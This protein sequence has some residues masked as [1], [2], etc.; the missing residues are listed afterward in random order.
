M[1]TLTIKLPQRLA[2]QLEA[3]ARRLNLPKSRMARQ[4]L[5]EGL[6]SKQTKGGRKKSFHDL[7]KEHCGSFR[8]PPDLSTNPK[9]MDGFA[10][11]GKR[12]HRRRAARGLFKR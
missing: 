4:F 7:A 11:E 9:Y 6:N 2:D 1:S 8:G 5:E 12:P 10:N 3:E